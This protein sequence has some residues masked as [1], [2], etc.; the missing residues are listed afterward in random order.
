MMDFP[1]FFIISSFFF[2]YHLASLISFFIS[3]YGF[4]GSVFCFRR[5]TML[6]DALIQLNSPSQMQLQ[7]LRNCTGLTCFEDRNQQSLLQA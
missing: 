6:C 5:W 4:Q 3:V 1:I 7:L 2:Q